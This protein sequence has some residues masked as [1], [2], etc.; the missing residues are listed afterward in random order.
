MEGEAG[1]SAGGDVGSEVC[2][3][4]EVAL[5]G[6]DITKN[7]PHKNSYMTAHQ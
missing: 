3:V 5:V 6:K 4:R 7:E 2:G 1:G